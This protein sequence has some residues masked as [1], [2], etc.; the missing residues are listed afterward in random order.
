MQAWNLV[1]SANAIML[2]AT[3][4]V[5]IEAF[6]RSHHF[7][8]HQQRDGSRSTCRLDRWYVDS[9]H[10][11]QVGT[12]IV[13]EPSCH[14]DHQAVFL[15]MYRPGGTRRRPRRRR[16]RRGL[17]YPLH[18]EDVALVQELF[19]AQIQP[20]VPKLL[21]MSPADSAQAWDDCKDAFRRSCLVE[22]RRHAAT[23]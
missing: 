13:A 20:L 23:R 4:P 22:I 2:D 21:E 17:R 16:G 10:Y 11:S 7:F 9:S 14:T 15:D 19:L 18:R 6:H 12:T 3:T 8:S 5:A 1:D